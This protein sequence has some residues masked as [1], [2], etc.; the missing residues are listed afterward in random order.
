MIR[1]D[2]LAHSPG[3]DFNLGRKAR[4]DDRRVIVGDGSPEQRGRRPDD[5]R[6][7]GSGAPAVRLRRSAR[8]FGRFVQRDDHHVFRG[9]WPGR[10]RRRSLI[11]L[12][13]NNRRSDVACRRCRSCPRP[14]SPAHRPASRCPRHHLAQHGDAAALVPR[15]A[16]ARRAGC[17]TPCTS[18]G[19]TFMPP[20]AI[21]R[22]GGGKVQ[23]AGG[24]A[25]AIDDGDRRRLRTSGGDQRLAGR[26][27]DHL[28]LRGSKQAQA[29]EEDPSA[30]R[31]RSSARSAP[32]PRSRT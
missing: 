18:V 7:Q 16:R 31:R 30:A 8:G 1:D 3:C 12:L 17:L 4:R 23:R 9:H 10:S 29:L 22:I 6:G 24:Y 13:R 19:V 21:G 15:T 5:G 28:D 25:V 20:L 32:C 14:H 26:R 2:L 27:L 11:T